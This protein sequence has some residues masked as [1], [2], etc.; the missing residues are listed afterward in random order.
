FFGGNKD[1]SGIDNNDVKQ[2]WD[3]AA[4]GDLKDFLT[5]R[6]WSAIP[7]TG[8]NQNKHITGDSN[9]NWK[10]CFK[11][12]YFGDGRA[13]TALSMG[14]G[15]GAFDRELKQRGLNFKSL[16]G[17]D[18]SDACIEKASREADKVGLADEV[19][20]YVSDLNHIDLPENKF[21]LIYFF[22]SLHHV[23]ELESVLG[24]CRRALKPDGIL[25]VN[26]YVGESRFQWN[27]EQIRYADEILAELS[28]E[29]KYDH[30]LQKQRDR[31][32]RVKLEDLIAMD[33]SEA[34]RSGDIDAVIKSIF[35]VVEEKNCGGTI[36]YLV[37][38]GV[39][40]NFKPDDTAHSS[41]IDSIIEKE[42]LLLEENKIK[43][44][45][46]YYVAKR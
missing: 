11:D 21:D 31:V 22:H 34:V 13:I 18:I 30:L 1:A 2:M 37:F 41:V 3:Q 36:T 19:D 20:Y 26:E 27:D 38:D 14:C 8:T 6:T 24:T 12:T 10:D 29:L 32:T 40:S 15:D 16:T 25:M 9:Y 35:N 42:N 39:A 7:Q 17:I 23:T 5:D 4:T 45:F 28:P 44:D 46:K 43:S 33:P